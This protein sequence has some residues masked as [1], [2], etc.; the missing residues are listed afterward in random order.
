MSVFSDTEIKRLTATIEVLV[1][2][3][4]EKDFVLWRDKM[5]SSLQGLMSPPKELNMDIRV[6]CEN[7]KHLFFR[8]YKARV[9]D[10]LIKSMTVPADLGPAPVNRNFK[11]VKDRMWLE[12]YFINGGSCPKAAKA[13]GVNRK[14]YYNWVNN[15]KEMIL[16]EQNKGVKN[17][18]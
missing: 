5:I 10:R 8:S 11:D 2:R 14:T 7:K 9:A 16:A 18:I 6:F 15:N 1:D 13:L 17:E 3:E 12:A 4:C